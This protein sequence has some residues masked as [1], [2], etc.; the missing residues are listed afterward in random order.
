MLYHDVDERDGGLFAP[1]A[2]LPT[3]YFDR[4]RRRTDLTGEQ[5]LMIAVL[6]AGVDDYLKYAA[7][8]SPRPRALFAAAEGWIE[9]DGRSWLY[10]FGTICDHLGLEAEHLR[11]G[12]R[13]SKARARGETMLRLSAGVGEIVPAAERRRA[14]NA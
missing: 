14:I 3:Q 5:R 11:A 1:G 7:A 6:E 10:D 4:L 2:L 13:R 9:S 12:L 8:R